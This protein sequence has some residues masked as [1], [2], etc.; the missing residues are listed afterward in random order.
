MKKS[1]F[2]YYHVSP[3]RFVRQWQRCNSVGEVAEALKMP[4]G[5]VASRAKSYIR[6]GIKLKQM[7]KR[8]SPYK[9]DVSAL[10]SLIE[11]ENK[12]GTPCKPK[13]K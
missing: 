3:E 13:G 10:N 4:K 1:C 7:P 8:N 11:E 12:K 9:I 2:R 5:A 6:K